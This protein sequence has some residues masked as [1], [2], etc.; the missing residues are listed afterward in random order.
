[1]LQVMSECVTEQNQK[2]KK[3]KECLMRK[4]PPDWILQEAEIRWSFSSIF[5]LAGLR[6]HQE[7]PKS[8]K[9]I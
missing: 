2:G 7:R 1:M 8:C 6:I 9:R 5:F 4:A 3:G